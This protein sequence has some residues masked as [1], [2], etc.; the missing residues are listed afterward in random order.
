MSTHKKSKGDAAAKLD[1][2]KATALVKSLA[3]LLDAPG[4]SK[5]ERQQVYAVSHHVS[6][7]LIQ[8]VANLAAEN[9]GSILG[10]GFDVEEARA[11]L[12]Y[13][14]ECKAVIDGARAFAQRVKDDVLARRQTIAE[15]ANVV[16]QALGRLVRTPEGK[17]LVQSY[18]QMHAV[19]TRKRTRA[20]RTGTA[21]A[22]PA[23]A[24]PSTQPS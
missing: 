23:A 7:A 24:S 21:A 15:H 3:Q 4:L 13:A 19:V 9:G 2:S 8:S 22:K 11:V 20:K 17:H 12:A 6:D 1:T 16:Y 18:E 10:M 5:A 14:S